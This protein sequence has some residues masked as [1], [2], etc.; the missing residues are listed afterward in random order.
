M[1]T[2]FISVDMIEMLKKDDFENFILARTKLIYEKLELLCG[3]K[4]Q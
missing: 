2:Q 3:N 4:K 1:E